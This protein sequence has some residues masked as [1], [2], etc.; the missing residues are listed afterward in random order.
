[1]RVV[2]RRHLVRDTERRPPAVRRV[3]DLRLLPVLVSA[4]RLHPAGLAGEGPPRSVRN[5]R[6]GYRSPAL[7]ARVR[8]DG[9]KAGE[10]I[11]YRRTSDLS[12]APRD[13][14]RPEAY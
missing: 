12:P 3:Q 8:V 1:M 5:C 6:R 14:L 10:V 9:Q 7:P 4:A 2:L 13:E 11:S